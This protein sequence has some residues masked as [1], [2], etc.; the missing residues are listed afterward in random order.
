MET[1]NE[2][3]TL[4]ILYLMMCFSDFV[5][6]IETRVII[7]ITFICTVSTYAI[8]HVFFMVSETYLQVKGKCKRCKHKRKLTKTQKNRQALTE[9]KM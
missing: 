6:K 9:A 4:L 7:G 8:V 1:F 3:M 2:I 5:P